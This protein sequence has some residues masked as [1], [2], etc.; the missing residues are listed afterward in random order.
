MVVETPFNQFFSNKFKSLPTFLS[1]CIFCFGKHITEVKWFEN[2]TL[3]CNSE[4]L[5]YSLTCMHCVLLMKRAVGFTITYST[6]AQK[7]YPKNY[8][9]G[10]CGYREIKCSVSDTKRL[11]LYCV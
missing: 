10:C 5:L 11:M 6:Q 4:Y 1:H 9:I 8:Y 2:L 3:K 7:F